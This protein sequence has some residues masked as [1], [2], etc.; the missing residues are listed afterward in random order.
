MKRVNDASGSK[1][2]VHNERARAA[3]PITPVG[4]SYTP[5]GQPDIN[6]LRTG[7]KPAV[8]TKPVGDSPHIRNLT[9]PS[10]VGYARILRID[11]EPSDTHQASTTS[12]RV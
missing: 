7:A 9:D 5:I 6:A 4:T 11:I 10:H 1:Y 2:S 3:A 8:A 12:S